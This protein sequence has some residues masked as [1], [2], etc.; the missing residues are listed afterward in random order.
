MIVTILTIIVII[1]VFYVLYKIFKLIMSLILVGVFLLI[2][3]V[4]NPSIESHRKEFQKEYPMEILKTRHVGL[5]DYYV[6]SLTTFGDEKKVIGAGA[7]TQ[8]F[9]FRSAE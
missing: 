1:I 4:T 5:E 6:F 7:F 9:I 2:A 3:Y 8:V